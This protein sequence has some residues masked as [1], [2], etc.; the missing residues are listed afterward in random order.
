MALVALPGISFA[1][2]DMRQG[3]KLMTL[4]IAHARATGS[5]QLLQTNMQ[6]RFNLYQIAQVVKRESPDVVAFQEIDHDSVW[7]GSFH[8][9]EFI[10]RL[11]DYP[12]VYGGAHVSGN[13]LNYGTALMTRQSLVGSQSVVFEKPIGRRGKGFVVSSINWP[14]AQG[15]HVDLVSVHL[16]FLTTAKRRAEIDRLISVVAARDR[17]RIVM[18]DFN[19][20]YDEPGLIPYLTDRLE[21][22]TWQPEKHAVTYPVLKRRLDW[23]LVSHDFEFLDHKV[24]PDTI[25]DHHAVIAEVTIKPRTG[26]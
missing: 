6:A 17:P 11:A 20:G 4:N 23:V 18:G 7:N 19:T 12:H 15:M 25:S 9:G 10:A 26:I 21:L 14:E 5:S 13:Y 24:L 3:V 8:H 1:S 16:D 22:H 2:Q